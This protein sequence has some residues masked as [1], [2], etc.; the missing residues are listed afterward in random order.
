MRWRRAVFAVLANFATSDSERLDPRYSSPLRSKASRS[1][2]FGPLSENPRARPC[3]LNGY[4][5][6]AVNAVRFLTKGCRQPL[7]TLIFV[8]LARR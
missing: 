4:L 8:S 6:W 3:A 5:S 1:L 7:G 2:I